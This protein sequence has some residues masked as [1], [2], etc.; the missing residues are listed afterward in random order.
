[1]V[2]SRLSLAFLVADAMNVSARVE[3]WPTRRPFRIAGHVWTASELLVVEVTDGKLKGR[4]EACGVYY[5]GDTPALMLDQILAAAEAL[6]ADVDS[7]ALRELLRSS[8]ARNAL[9]AALWDLQA[10]RCGTPVWSQAKL[11]RPRP[12]R[13][14]WTIG[15][16][17][18][19]TMAEL[20]RELVIARALKL[21]LNGDGLDADRVSAVRQ[22]RPDAWIGVD[23]NQGLTRA[24]L[25]KLLPTLVDCDVRLIEQPVPVGQEA[26]LRGLSLPIPLAA[27]ESV[28]DM[29]DLA[30]AALWAQVVNIKLDKC[31]GLTRGL[32]IATRARQMGLEVMVGCMLG[33]SLA[34]APA[35]LLGQG[36][37]F[38]DLDGP[39]L[40]AR[41]REPSAVYRDG[42]IWCP[43]QLWGGALS[44]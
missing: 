21:K 39:T 24:T 2:D 23:A 25:L 20:A 33:T 12:L 5:K 14:T 43:E 8:G 31:G 36:C 26:Q 11:P 18:P 13:T 19:Q 6:S 15:A 34:M 16:D 38:V 32:E 17:T 29:E 4:G 9:D 22:A 1:M 27:D 42:E 30:D 3:K 40:L 41:D 37:P 35:F 7:G 28:Q 10:Q 44:C